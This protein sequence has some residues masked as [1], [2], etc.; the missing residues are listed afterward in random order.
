MY[1]EGLAGKGE[2]F[3][4]YGATPRLEVGFGYLAKQNT[5]RPLASYTFVPEANKRPSLTAGLMFD[6][7]GGGRQGVF[8]S[9]AKDLQSAVGL[10]ASLYVGGAKIT[11]ERGV[12]LL[13][14]TNVRLTRKINASVQFDGRY[15]NLGLTTEIGSVAGTTVRFGLVAAGGNQIGPLF[16]TSLPLER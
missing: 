13:A 9:V 5:I 3:L 8:V 12:R 15:A 6:S 10:P 16:A 7:L 4:R 2:T 1:S 14:G 11:N